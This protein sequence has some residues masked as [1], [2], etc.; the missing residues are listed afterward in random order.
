MQDDGEHIPH[1]AITLQRLSRSFETAATA[2]EEQQ[3]QQ[4]SSY[5]HH[6][7]TTSTT[8]STTSTTIPHRTSADTTS[9]SSPSLSEQAANEPRETTYSTMGT[10]L[11][12]KPATVWDAKDYSDLEVVVDS[13]QTWDSNDK[14][15]VLV[16][17][18]EEKIA[19]QGMMDYH[20]HN[21]HHHQP[22][23]LSPSLA[24]PV[25]AYPASLHSRTSTFTNS[26]LT[27]GG[28]Y[29]EYVQQVGDA[30]S[31]RNNGKKLLGMS[32][33]RLSIVAAGLLGFILILLATVL[34]ITL[35]MNNDR[36]GGR[37]VSLGASGSGNLLN[38]SRLAALNWTD[39]TGLDRSLVFYQDAGSSIMVSI[40]DSVSNEWAVTNITQAVVN[41]TGAKRLDVM[42]GTPLAAVTNLW[43]VSL[44]YLTS[45]NFLSEIWCSDVATGVWYA[46][47]LAAD[48]SP[49]VMN[50]S[51]L[52][53]FWQLCANCSDSLV[54]LHQQ[55][56][57]ALML[58]NFTNNNWDMSGP[59]AA[60]GSGVVNQTGLA[61]R[62][63]A[64]GSNST[65]AGLGA[66]PNG[67]RAYEFDSTGIVELTS[68]PAN[69]Y[70]WEAD[71]ASKLA[72]LRRG[73]TRRRRKRLTFFHSQQPQHDLDRGGPHP[74]ARGRHVR[75]PRL[76]QQRRDVPDERRR[77]DV[78]R[79]QRQ[80]RLDQRAA[81][82]RGG[83]RHGQQRRRRQ[84]EGRQQRR[85]LAH[86]HR[87]RRHAGHAH[88]RRHR[89]RDHPRVRHGRRGP[90]EL[91]AAQHR[92]HH[93][94]Q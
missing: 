76:D 65:T 20:H 37:S 27:K 22:M 16:D 71:D 13:Q 25:P 26:P 24:D 38:T 60:A 33:K 72:L 29:T 18:S 88:I 32:N 1:G 21:S 70:T 53:A 45:H 79:A 84:E 47:S 42:P 46:G 89:Q 9:R 44:Y 64:E 2:A 23:L 15:P 81:G 51:R 82:A 8:S 28:D 85:G 40:R 69:N 7:A 11:P 67:W 68:G 31:S 62:P 86:L 93:H 17:T 90:P 36:S 63:A 66:E 74:R 30:G 3:Q 58:A 94:G 56:D 75:P 61:I 4:S 78:V 77:A 35:S 80:R 54:V 6:Y 73:E 39:T 34:A 14:M 57:G 41:S 19:A 59:V 43:Q 52:A 87:P 48:L 50:G 91:G 10:G 55:P 83:R 12:T 5:Y 92:R 49:Q